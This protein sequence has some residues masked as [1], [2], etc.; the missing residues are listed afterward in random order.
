M[1]IHVNH[2]GFFAHEVLQRSE[3]A[4][5]SGI[6]SRGIYIQPKGEWTLYLSLEKYCGPLTLNLKE[7][8]AKLD[9]FNAG[10]SVQLSPEEL[11]FP[12]EKITIPLQDS[13][14]WYPP[15]VNPEIKSFAGDLDSILSLV[16]KI[17]PENPFLPLLS[18]N[19]GKIPGVAVIGERI[20]AFQNAMGAGDQEKLAKAALQLLGLGPGLTPLGDDFLLGVLLALNRWG[21]VLTI[22]LRE[23]PNSEKGGS[24]PIQVSDLNQIILEN[25]PLKTTQISA[26]L[27]ACAVEGA[28]DERLLVILDGLFSGSEIT[29]NEMR[30]MLRWGNS[31]GIT[32]LAGILSILRAED[33]AS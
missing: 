8:S 26:S 22:D 21:H 25:T 2:I 14:V 32:V 19:P 4:L 33:A 7:G 27:L 10:G 16:N 12:D 20:L 24:S 28:A 31:S 29:Q 23:N 6:A 1:N 30:N 5:V 9:K 17:I 3:R 15:P 18:R 13:T 11:T